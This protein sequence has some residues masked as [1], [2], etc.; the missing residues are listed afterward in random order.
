VR[1]D[2]FRNDLKALIG[3]GAAGGVFL[4][5]YAYLLSKRSHTM[6]DVQLLVRT[7][8]P[9]LERFPEYIGLAVLLMLALGVAIKRLDLRDRGFIFALSLALVPFAVFNQQVIT[10]QSLQPIHY[11]V[12]IGNYV[13]G[14]SLAAVLGLLLRGRSVDAAGEVWGS[15]F[16]PKAT[17]AAVAVAAVLWGFVECHY[18]VRVLD[19]MN[20]LRDQQIPLARRLT[21]LAKNDTDPHKT[22]VL[23]LAIAEADDL[24]TIAPQATLWARHQH[25]FAGV[26]WQENKERYY[27]YLYFQGITEQQLAHGMKN[28]DYVS[29]IALFGWGRHTERLNSDFK[30]LTYGEIDAEA[31]NYGRYI[32]NFDPRNSPETLLTYVIMPHD[33]DVDLSNLDRW[34]IR[35]QGDVFGPYTLFHVH[36]RPDQ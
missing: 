21:E 7:H 11:Q 33:L 5:P 28:G 25:V 14:L 1:P 20:V 30:P 31:E 19:D 29:M 23:H 18:T 16:W 3:V 24:P 9:D 26:T 2:G 15:Q 36:L 6:D 27:Q 22:N 12:F 32:R 17:F 8:A 13:A 4:V 35:D 10:G 34:Y